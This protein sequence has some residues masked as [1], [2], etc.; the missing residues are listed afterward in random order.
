MVRNRKHKATYQIHETF[1]VTGK[2]II[3]TGVILEGTFRIGD[4]IEFDSNGQLFKRKIQGIDARSKIE[5]GENV[6]ILLEFG[7]EEEI[8]Y[9]KNWKST[10]TIGYICESSRLNLFP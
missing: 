3:L 4:V 8:E 5:K 9:L 1:A 6:G 2:G 7:N 10:Q